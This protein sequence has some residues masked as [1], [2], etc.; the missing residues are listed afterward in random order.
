MNQVQQPN[1][2]VLKKNNEIRFNQLWAN[3]AKSEPNA[4]RISEYIQFVLERGLVSNRTTLRHFYNLFLVSTEKR[5]SMEPATP[6][7]PGNLVIV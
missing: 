3:I 1:S 4:M 2:V 7:T 6:I 5:T